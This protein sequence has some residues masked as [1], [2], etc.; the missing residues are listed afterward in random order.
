MRQL[1]RAL[2]ECSTRQ[3]DVWSLGVILYQMLFGRRPFGD[4]CTQTQLL[5]DQVML[6]ARAVTF[7]AKPAVSAEAKAFVQQCASARPT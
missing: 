3:V 5:R 6:N 4:G 2:I 7:P 1:P